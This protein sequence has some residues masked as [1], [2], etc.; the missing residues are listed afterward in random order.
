MRVSVSR[1]VSD[2]TILNPLQCN[3][4]KMDGKM[5][6]E[7]SNVSGVN[8]FAVLL[9]LHVSMLTLK[10]EGVGTGYLRGTQRRYRVTG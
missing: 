10:G 8:Q 5:F 6:F 7:L 3:A 4:A 9:Y 2:F 1:Q